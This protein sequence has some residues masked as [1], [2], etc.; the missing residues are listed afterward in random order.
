V[1]GVLAAYRKALS[2]VRLSGPT[3]FAPVLKACCDAADADV[4]L[5]PPGG[6]SK[7]TV[8]LIITDGMIMDM[9][10]T[11]DACVRASRLPVSV[12]IVG[13]GAADFSGMVDLDSDKKRMVGR[14]GAAARD[15]VQFVAM[16]DYT[17]LGSGA[18]LARD[19]LAEVPAQVTSYFASKG[20]NPPPPIAPEAAPEHAESALAQ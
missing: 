8:L 20:V 6:L 14:N 16:T 18:R 19:V 10:E 9:D 15:C 11:I 3:C 17:G 1:D 13:V 7:Y 12:I 4:K 5:T 2:A